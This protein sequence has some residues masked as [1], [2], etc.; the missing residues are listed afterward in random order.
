M[1]VG[2]WALAARAKADT[3]LRPP[4]SEPLPSFPPS[5]ACLER[6]DVLGHLLPRQRLPRLQLELIH[7]GLS[8]ARRGLVGGDDHAFHARGAVQGGDRHEGDD[9]GAV[10]VGHDAALAGLGGSRGGTRAF[11]SCGCGWRARPTTPHAPPPHPPRP[12][13]QSSLGSLA[14]PAFMPAIASGLISGMTRGT[15]GVIRKA[16]ELSTTYID[17]LIS[18]LGIRVGS[19]DGQGRAASLPPPPPCRHRP[20]LIQPIHPPSTHRTARIRGGVGVLFG[21]RPARRKQSNVDPLEAVKGL[22]F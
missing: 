4:P 22:N 15:P 16:D 21:D 2:G 10:G 11:G 5:P 12:P 3:G 8:R 13:A 7:R 17:G 18:G 20:H 14:L 19:G 9:G 1:G 6:K